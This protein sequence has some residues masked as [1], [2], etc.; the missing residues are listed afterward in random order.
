MHDLVKQQKITKDSIRAFDS[1][2]VKYENDKME[3]IERLER[4]KDEVARR[5]DQKYDTKFT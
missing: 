4:E 2:S 5:E 3:L 1:L